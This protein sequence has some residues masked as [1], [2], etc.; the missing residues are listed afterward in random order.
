MKLSITSPIRR[1]ISKL[2]WI[3]AFIFLFSC[4]SFDN[5]DVERGVQY[6]F[7]EGY[8]EVRASAF[9]YYD[10]QDNAQIDIYTDI[11][12]KSLIFKSNKQNQFTADLLVEVRL[13]DQENPEQT[14]LTKNYPL[15]ITSKDPDIVDSGARYSFKKQL[16]IEPGTYTLRVFVTDKGSNKQTVRETEVSIPKKEAGQP[17]LSNILMLGK[18]V[19][20]TNEFRSIATYDVQTSLDSLKFIIQVNNPNQ[21]R[22]T[23]NSELLEFESDTS[24]ARPMSYRNYS[25]SSIQ[26]QGINYFNNTV[27]QST[28]RVISQQGNLLIEY[29]YPTPH[30]GNYRF[31]TAITESAEDLRES[32]YFKARDFGIKSK[33]YPNIKSPEELARPLIYLMDE[34]DHQK[35]M[36][37]SDSNKLKRAVDKFW[38]SHLKSRNVA[39]DHIEKY[40][41]RV[42]RAN[43]QFSN[44]KEGWKTDPGMV[45]ILFGPPR[46]VDNFHDEMRW[47]YTTNIRDA[48]YDYVF[49]RYRFKSKYYPFENYILQRDRSF[50]QDE[51]RQ[52]QIWLTSGP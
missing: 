15:Q 50:F 41:E 12:Y 44:Y 19:Q 28:R 11:V 3:G 17:Y 48:I 14:K 45:Y 32:E 34:K 9:G 7:R 21:E 24:S 35:M 23:L 10:Q 33:N 49:R 39:R 52:R 5:S 20:G 29:V 40:Y 6:E 27:I 51:Y 13:I 31:Q 8:P 42:E 30:R 36:K 1:N 26:F 37:I 18:D 38:L 25:R 47:G 43:K 2:S 16:T 22:L 46:Y 4:S